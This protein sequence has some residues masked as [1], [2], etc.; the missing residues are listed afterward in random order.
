MLLA[1]PEH[2]QHVA[3]DGRAVH[4]HGLDAAADV[5]GI[6]DVEDVGGP[7]EAAADARDEGFEGQVKD[8]EEL[9]RC[10]LCCFGNVRLSVCVEWKSP[11]NDS[12]NK[13]YFEVWTKGNNK[14]CFNTFAAALARYN[15]EKQKGL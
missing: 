6:L 11:Y 15:Q 9:Q 10:I 12:F 2:W 8:S 5:S 4:G 1:V 3:F 7:A 13:C 14:V